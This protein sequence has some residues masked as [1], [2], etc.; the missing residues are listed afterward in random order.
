MEASNA[1]RVQQRECQTDLPCPILLFRRQSTGEDRDK[2]QVVDTEHDLQGGQCQ[3]ARPDFQIDYPIH[4]NAYY[5]LQDRPQFAA[6][7]SGLSYLPTGFGGGAVELRTELP[8]GNGDAPVVEVGPHLID[9][10]RIARCF[11]VCFYDGFGITLCL[12]AARQAQS[13]G[14]PQPEQ[15]IASGGDPEPPLLIALELGFEPYFAFGEALQ[16]SLLLMS[17]GGPSPAIVR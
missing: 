2:E 5:P 13:R 8:L 11:E 9:D 7:A 16:R 14:R 1:R 10:V 15:P 3:K 4:S 6:L 17:S 12:L